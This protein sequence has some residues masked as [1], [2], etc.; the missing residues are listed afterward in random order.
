MIFFKRFKYSRVSKNMIQDDNVKYI[1]M[2]SNLE[3]VFENR[4]NKV[5]SVIIFNILI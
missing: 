4:K 1:F 3:Y 2:K 5:Y